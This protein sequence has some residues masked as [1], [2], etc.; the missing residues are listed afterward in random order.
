MCC[1][2][3]SVEVGILIGFSG[4]VGVVGMRCVVE[5]LMVGVDCGG[6]REVDG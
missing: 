5:L 6:G 1:R 4:G 3:G 2:G